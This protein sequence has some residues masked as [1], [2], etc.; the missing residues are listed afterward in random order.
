MVGVVH[1][2]HIQILVSGHLP[3]CHCSRP[4]Y[5]KVEAA[6][7][8]PIQQSINLQLIYLNQSTYISGVEDSGESTDKD[9]RSCSSL[10]VVFTAQASVISSAKG[11]GCVCG[12]RLS[13]RLKLSVRLSWKVEL[14][15]LTCVRMQQLRLSTASAAAVVECHEHLVKVYASCL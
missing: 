8:V 14:L 9:I 15:C 6:V 5:Q 13:I 11:C 12:C 4:V 2:H 10:V 7:V 1:M 3:G